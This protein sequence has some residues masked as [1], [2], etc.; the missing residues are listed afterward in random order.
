M[1]RSFKKPW[2]KDRNPFMKRVAN[3]KVRRPWNWEKIGDG[4][5]YRKLTDP[6]DI[7][8]WCW[9]VDP[10]SR[11]T[12]HPWLRN[13]YDLFPGIWERECRRHKMIYGN[14]RARR[15]RQK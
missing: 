13:Y 15:P 12:S 11:E 9:V 3:R 1:A 5:A 6:W 2:V 7:S 4:K 14:A 10:P 8:D